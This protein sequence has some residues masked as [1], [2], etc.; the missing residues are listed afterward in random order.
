M[1]RL[2]IAV[3]LVVGLA[4]CSPASKRAMTIGDREA[5]RIGSAITPASERRRLIRMMNRI[6]KTH[7]RRALHEIEA[8]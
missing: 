8:R 7:R 1:I 5:S 4:G 3:A 2:G 6:K